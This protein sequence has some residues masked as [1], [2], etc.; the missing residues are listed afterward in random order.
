MTV[1]IVLGGAPRVP[2]TRWRPG[3]A[4]KGALGVLLL[5]AAWQLSVPLVG[6]GAYFYPAPT[7][8]AVAFVD[9]IRKGILPVYLADSVERYLAGLT[10]GAVLGIAFGVL[11]GLNRRASPALSPLFKFLFAI[12]EVAWIPLFVVWFGFTDRSHSATCRTSRRTMQ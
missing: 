8:V 12:V 5:L 6:L 4:A 10:L 7:D 3:R 2:R 11:I 9:L 1:D